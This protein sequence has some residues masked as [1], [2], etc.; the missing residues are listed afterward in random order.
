MN[1][2]SRTKV[3]KAW[4][5]REAIS[6]DLDRIAAKFS[7][8]W[9]YT[10]NRSKIIDSFCSALFKAEAYLDESTLAVINEDTLEEALVRA[11][12]KSRYREIK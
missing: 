8:Q 6:N 12:C 10:L 11:I 3:H 4:S 2:L 5:T 7:E 9:S 1:K